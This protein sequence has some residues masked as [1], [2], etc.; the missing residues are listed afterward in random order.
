MIRVWDA[1]AGCPEKLW[2]TS[3]GRRSRSGWA[4]LLSSVLQWDVCLPAARRLG[5]G[6]LKMSSSPNSSMNQG[7]R[8][9]L[10]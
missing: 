6:S 10:C 2:M 5:W 1:E 3:D 8:D 4:G 7:K 9:V